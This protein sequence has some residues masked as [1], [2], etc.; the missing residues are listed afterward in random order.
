MTTKLLIDTRYQCL[1]LSTRKLEVLNFKALLCSGTKFAVVR[2]H[3]LIVDALTMPSCLEPIAWTTGST[4]AVGCQPTLKEVCPG[5]SAINCPIAVLRV[6][7]RLLLVMQ[8]L[9]CLLAHCPTR[10]ATPENAVLP[11]NRTM[12]LP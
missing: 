10:V 6:M 12:N 8:L 4:S 7:L 9:T 5:L 1:S 11:S 2:Y 3:S